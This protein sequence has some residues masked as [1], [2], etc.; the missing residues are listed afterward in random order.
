M[1]KMYDSNKAEVTKII[2][3]YSITPQRIS[4]AKFTTSWMHHYDGLKE[5]PSWPL[6]MKSSTLISE[7][8]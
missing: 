2:M 8:E 6:Q 5:I 4:F 1:G 3:F 7:K